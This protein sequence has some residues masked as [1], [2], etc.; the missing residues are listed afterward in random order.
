M[1][2]RGI[3]S[4]LALVL[5]VA[6]PY[7]SLADASTRNLRRHLNERELLE[8]TRIFARYAGPRGH[9]LAKRCARK[10][11][12]DRDDD[13]VIIFEGNGLCMEQL[14]RD[15][16]IIDADFDN[17]VF[18]LGSSGDAS[19]R[20]LEEIMPW[21]LEMIQADQ[22][23][24]GDNEVTVCIVD[25][26]IARDHPDFDSSM[27]TG[28]DTVGIFWKWKWDTD[29]S[30]HG[31]HVAGIIAALAANDQGTAG[32]GKF[33]LHITRAIGDGKFAY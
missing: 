6:S 20:V 28:N 14:Q 1:K 31:T 30:G 17:K 27:I 29:V 19:S 23:E 16:D 3:P 11:I 26:G 5:L 22:L 2:R 21:G 8:G 25:S 9:R 18:P 13:D 33:R 4:L 12:R 32:A 24:V 10:I 15:M 7:L